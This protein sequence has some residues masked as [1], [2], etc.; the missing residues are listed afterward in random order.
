MQDSI[1]ENLSLKLTIFV[2]LLGTWFYLIKYY[3]TL[4]P[5][6]VHSYW[7][8]CILLVSYII[9]YPLFQLGILLIYISL[10]QIEDKKNKINI[11]KKIYNEKA[12]LFWRWWAIALFFVPIFII[13]SLFKSFIWLALLLVL[14]YI[15]F[16]KFKIFNNIFTWNEL[17]IFFEKGFYCFFIY[18]LFFI[19]VI[20]IGVNLF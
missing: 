15:L 1:K 6:T 11:L 20:G 19:V 4:I 10:Y 17:K 18:I 13:L 12:I 3:L 14:M 9:F 8:F 5:I 16:F 2:A 7:A